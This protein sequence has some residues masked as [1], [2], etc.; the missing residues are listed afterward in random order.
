MERI[1][2]ILITLTIIFLGLSYACFFVFNE[3]TLIFLSKEDGVFENIGTISFLLAF[4]GFLL[5]F[6]K[7]KKGNDFGFLKFKKNIFYLF[8]SLMFFFAFGEEISWGQRI[9]NFRTPEILEEVNIQHECT[10]HNLAIFQDSKF[11][12]NKYAF[13]T[14]ITSF[15]FMFNIFCLVYCGLIPVLNK[16]SKRIRNFLNKINSPI[17]PLWTGLVFFLII[18]GLEIAENIIPKNIRVLVYEMKETQLAFLF[19]VISFWFLNKFYLG[20]GIVNR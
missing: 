12:R 11:L 9:F 15:N 13:W 10:I 6:M 20:N 2:K 4:L 14:G 19:F 7:S 16:F 17:V 1:N 5:C 8:L 18:F 3:K